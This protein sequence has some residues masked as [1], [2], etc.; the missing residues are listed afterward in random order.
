MIN[1]VNHNTESN[2][3]SS[4]VKICSHTTYLDCTSQISDYGT[5][6]NNRTT[7]LITYLVEL[8]NR[9]L[10]IQSHEYRHIKLAY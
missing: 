8:Q 5:E 10:L 4:Q 3:H 1:H 9:E 7:L 2:H 6:Q